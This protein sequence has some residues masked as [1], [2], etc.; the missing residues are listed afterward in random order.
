MPKEPNQTEAEY[1]EKAAAAARARYQ[2]RTRIAKP[3]GRPSLS[4]DTMLFI[5]L[6]ACGTQGR[7][8]QGKLKKETLARFDKLHALDPSCIAPSPNTLTDYVKRYL[9]WRRNPACIKDFPDHIQRG[10]A[11]LPSGLHV[12]VLLGAA[13]TLVS[14]LA[15]GVRATR[16]VDL[17]RRVKS[18]SSLK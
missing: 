15:T 17:T 12:D 11:Q 13:G 18:I 4:T 3:V 10:I 7:L 6:A 2:K 16:Q 14:G 9:Q 1:V 5:H 8:T